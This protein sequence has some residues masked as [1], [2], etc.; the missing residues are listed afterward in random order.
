MENKIDRDT[1]EVEFNRWA[2]TWDIDTDVDNMSEEDEK[3]FQA[4]KR[5]VIRGLMD[6]S[7]CV[8]DEGDLNYK[9]KFSKN[10]EPG[11]VQLKISRADILSMDRYKDQQ[12][13]HKI[14]AYLATL[15]GLP[16][17]AMSNIDPRDQKR[18]RG[19]VLLFLGS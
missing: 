10:F 17:K 6:G 15:A 5:L 12:S 19:P 7:F 11:E 2:L 9:T 16:T 13:M 8:N 1:A 4:A 14:Q 3:S 18:L